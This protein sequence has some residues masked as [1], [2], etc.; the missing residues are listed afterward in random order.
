ML[1]S[2][3]KPNGVKASAGIA[4]SSGW[5][6]LN[7]KERCAKAAEFERALFERLVAQDDAVLALSQLYQVYLASMSLSG[8]PIGTL[9]FLGPTGS[10][11]TR[12][13]EAAAEILFDDPYAMIKVDCAEF[14]HSHEISKL[15]G[16]PPGYLGHR[17]TMPLLTQEN[18]DRFHTPETKLTL[19]LFDEIE[20]ASD[21]LWHLLLGILDMVIPL[22]NLVATKQIDCG[23]VLHVDFDE[24]ARQLRFTK[25]ACAAAAL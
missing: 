13:V 21:A 12:S 15:I 3:E 22:S 14:Q 5:I 7:A 8:K 10:G 1:P 19:V 23:D 24:Q 11:K 2:V 20:K 9:L 25:A 18:L 6:S 4:I 16:S 17:D